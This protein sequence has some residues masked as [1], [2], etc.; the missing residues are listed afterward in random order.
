[1]MVKVNKTWN[2]AV[3]TDSPQRY[4]S[5]GVVKVHK[6]IRNVTIVKTITAA[7]HE[8]SIKHKCRGENF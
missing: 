6:K 3:T 1:M 7:G 5:A 8:G 4:R 2:P